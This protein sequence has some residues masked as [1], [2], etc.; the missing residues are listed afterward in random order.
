MPD[1]QYAHFGIPGN[2]LSG[3]PMDLLLPQDTADMV[4]RAKKAKPPPE[5]YRAPK[6]ENP[7]ISDTGG[8]ASKSQPEVFGPAEPGSIEDLTNR[9]LDKYIPK[10]RSPDPGYMQL[11][12]PVEPYMPGTQGFPQPPAYYKTELPSQ[13]NVPEPVSALDP[14]YSMH[15]LVHLLH[16]S[17]GSTPGST[18][19]MNAGTPWMQLASEFYKPKKM[20]KSDLITALGLPGLDMPY[21]AQGESVG[22][23]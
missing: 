13:M 19:P 4:K 9:G 22:K 18:V 3:S 2:P 17:L 6:M 14:A 10:P 15:P 21:E 11:K 8:I 16:N 5:T 23:T 1:D 12:P 20:T 7:G